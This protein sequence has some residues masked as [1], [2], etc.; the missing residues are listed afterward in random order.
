MKALS[1]MLASSRHVVVHT[2]AGISTSAGE[3]IT[4]SIGV[5]WVYHRSQFCRWQFFVSGIIGIPDFRGPKGVWTLEKAGK[6]VEVSKRFEDTEPTLTHQALVVLAEAG[7]IKHVVSQNVDGLHLKSG[8]PRW[9]P[10]WEC[11]GSAINFPLVASPHSVSPHLGQ[12]SLSSMAMSSWRDVRSVEGNVMILFC[13][14][15]CN[16]LSRC[17]EYVRETVVPTIGLQYTGN[18]CEGGGAKGR[19]R[20]VTFRVQC[21]HQWPTHLHTVAPLANTPNALL[22]YAM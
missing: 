16:Q 17:R 21:G 3:V 14:E 15:T 11:H 12:V 5:D 1:E 9:M 8:L 6:R 2:G 22:C 19:C 7:Y 4:M 20:S 10:L 18:R 13:Q